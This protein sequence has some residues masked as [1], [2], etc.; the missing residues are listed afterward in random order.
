MIDDG[1]AQYNNGYLLLPILDGN[2]TSRL[3]SDDSVNAGINTAIWE[4]VIPWTLVLG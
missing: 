3:P 4:L 1:P 2:V